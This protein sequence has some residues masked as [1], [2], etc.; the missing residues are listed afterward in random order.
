MLITNVGYS[1]KV[2]QVL[3]KYYNKPAD[4][5]SKLELLY[6]VTTVSTCSDGLEAA[7]RLG[8]ACQDAMLIVFMHWAVQGK[9]L[10]Q[11]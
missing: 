7:S 1:V 9:E 11:G 5:L 2:L 4:Y 6:K 10:D 8:I 3:Y